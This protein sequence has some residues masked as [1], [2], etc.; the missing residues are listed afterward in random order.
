[1]NVHKFVY[2]GVTLD[3]NVDKLAVDARI[4]SAVDELPVLA[5]ELDDSRGTK[6]LALE[7]LKI[8]H[9]CVNKIF[10]RDDAAELLFGHVETLSEAQQAFMDVVTIIGK[11]RSLAFNN[12]TKATQKIAE[13]LKKA[14]EAA[15]ETGD[16]T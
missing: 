1:M 15:A 16:A 7:Y 6:S 8:V 11:M 13:G 10:D 3:L 14:S 12:A 2:R 5:K 9:I 4:Q